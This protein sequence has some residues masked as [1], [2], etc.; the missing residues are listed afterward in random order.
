[1]CVICKKRV[2]ENMY[3]ED[4]DHVTCINCRSKNYPKF[5]NSSQY[6]R[7]WQTFTVKWRREHPEDDLC[8]M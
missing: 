7:Y 3:D 1:M 8:S 4:I 5:M 2:S 6:I